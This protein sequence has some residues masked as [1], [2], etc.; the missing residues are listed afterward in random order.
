LK[1]EFVCGGFVEFL[2]RLR[3][4]WRLFG[5]VV[6]FVL[7]SFVGYSIQPIRFINTYYTRYSWWGNTT[8]RRKLVLALTA[9]LV[10]AG[11]I[12]TVTTAAVLNSSQTLS[13]IGTVA[14]QPT[15]NI[16]VY[17]DSACTQSAS[18]VSWG[19]L[20]P[21]DSTTRTVWIKNLGTT[22]ATL[23][24]STN[25][26][27]PANANTW[28]SV[29]WDANGRVLAPNGVTQVTITLSVSASVD[30]SISAFSFNILI[31]GTG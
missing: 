1:C 19:T 27:S 9:A 8:A 6:V 12:L 18:S 15:L 10:I 14:I 30:S 28:I 26:W 16:G 17:A 23:S 13:T 4:V 21:G 20:N 2:L 29:T 24:M 3:S 22:S 31:T 5:L 7:C 11:L 25:N